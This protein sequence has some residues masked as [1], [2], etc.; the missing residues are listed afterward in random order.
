MT[1]WPK[2]DDFIGVEWSNCNI[3]LWRICLGIYYDIFGYHGIYILGFRVYLWSCSVELSPDPAAKGWRGDAGGDVGE[4]VRRGWWQGGLYCGWRGGM[5]RVGYRGRRAG[6]WVIHLNLDGPSLQDLF[7]HSCNSFF[8][9]NLTTRRCFHSRVLFD[10]IR[11][12]D[13]VFTPISCHFTWH[14]E[15]FLFEQTGV[16]AASQNSICRLHW[17]ISFEIVLRSC[18]MVRSCFRHAWHSCRLCSFL[19]FKVAE[20]TGEGMEAR[21]RVLKGWRKRWEVQ[22]WQRL[23]CKFEELRRQHLLER[24]DELREELR[25]KEYEDGH[26][27]TH[28]KRSQAVTI[29][30]A[31]GLLGNPRYNDV[32]VKSSSRCSLSC[33]FCRAN[34]TTQ[35]QNRSETLSFWT[36]LFEIELWLQSR[37]HFAV[38]TRPH[39]SKAAPN[40]T[41]FCDFYVKSSS[42]YS[43]M[44]IFP[45]PSS[46]RAP[47]ATA[48]REVRR[49]G[50]TTARMAFQDFRISFAVSSMR[51]KLHAF[52]ALP[53]PRCESVTHEIC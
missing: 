49:Q 45:T 53:L 29:K 26:C 21:Q 36:F 25:A 43:L 6:W 8:W 44:H 50:I 17:S 2:Y 5:G 4:M 30:A 47:N 10:K 20:Q 14:W 23:L 27:A 40:V 41:V 12:H 18:S 22:R 48:K 28:K 1:T 33:T 35:I 39:K 34:L 32:R 24:L 31:V 16:L 13:D 7:F 3:E 9:I 37:A 42:G 19:I 15:G 52:A 51:G 46:K 38:R 11:P